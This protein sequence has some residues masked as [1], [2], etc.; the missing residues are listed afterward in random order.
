MAADTA[1]RSAAA[2]HPLVRAILDAFPGSS[3]DSVTDTRVDVY[4]LLAESVPLDAE[5]T[6][7]EDDS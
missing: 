4:G 2:V 3:I 7:M 1:R 5:M 6:D